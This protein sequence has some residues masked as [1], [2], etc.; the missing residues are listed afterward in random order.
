MRPEVQEAYG[1]LLA[2][3]DATP[4]T[5]AQ[6]AEVNGMTFDPRDVSA[7]FEARANGRTAPIP[8][9]LINPGDGRAGAA[10]RGFGDPLGLDRKSTR[11]TSSHQCASR[12]PSSA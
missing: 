12:M 2:A 7:Y 5:L 3:P 11:L 8:L 10:A 6:F 9:P 4:E 1:S